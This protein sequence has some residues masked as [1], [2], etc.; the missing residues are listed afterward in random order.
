MHRASDDDRAATPRE[1]RL[2]DAAASLINRYGYDKTTVEDIAREAGISKGAVYLHVGS[3]L[4]L[5]E[6]LLMREMERY[7]THWLRVVLEDPNPC[8][9]G[10]MVRAML[11]ALDDNPFMSAML[12]EDEQ[13]LGQ[14][15]RQPDNLLR[16]QSGRN[17]KAMLIEQMQK[18]GVVRTDIDPEIAAHVLKMLSFGLVSMTRITSSDRI[19]ALAPLV[20]AIATMLDSWMTP[21]LGFDPDAGRSLL[22]SMMNAARSGSPAGQRA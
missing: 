14:Y 18:A 17:H 21:L 15:L 8:T 12:G 1:T 20:D 9:M 19:P 22:K 7:A 6:R 2:L 5:F 13:V 16:Q 10:S 3:K 4:E 11:L